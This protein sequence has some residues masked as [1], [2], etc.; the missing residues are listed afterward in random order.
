VLPE[1]TSLR[2]DAS[3]ARLVRAAFALVLCAT[4]ACQPTATIGVYRDASMRCDP[5]GN[6]C[7]PSMACTLRSDPAMDACRAVGALA[8]G[9]RC[10]MLDACIAG[11]QCARL[12]PTGAS[13]APASLSSGATCRR[14]CARDAP[15]C[16]ASERCIDIADE[17]GHTRLD[18]GLCGP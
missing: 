1:P 4:P 13:L 11:S 16:D 3:A 8:V 15:S 10:T 6:D 14:V 2:S 9:A 7:G 12:D 5:L 17:S 18:F